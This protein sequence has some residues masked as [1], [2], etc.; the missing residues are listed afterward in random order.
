MRYV[1]S[2]ARPV[3]AAIVEL[4]IDAPTEARAAQ[5][6]RDE[7][8][9]IPDLVETIEE[10]EV[11]GTRDIAGWCASCDGP[12]FHGQ[13]WFRPTMS[14]LMVHADDWDCEEAE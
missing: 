13:E 1:V 6:F 7:T 2:G 12:I 3:S 9:T 5:M 4:D 14:E 10:G 11:V 8:G